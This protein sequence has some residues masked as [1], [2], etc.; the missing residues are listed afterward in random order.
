MTVTRTCNPGDLAVT[1]RLGRQ[2]SLKYEVSVSAADIQ[3]VIVDELGTR[4]LENPPCGVSCEYEWP[5]GPG[6][7]PQAGDEVTYTLSMQ[8]LGSG[9]CHYVVTLQDRDKRPLKVVKDCLFSN[10]NGP[11][12]FFE[13]LRIFLEQ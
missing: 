6:D 11:D 4:L 1:V 10:D 13:A 2:E 5:A 7:V 8:F 9:E 3:F 12:D